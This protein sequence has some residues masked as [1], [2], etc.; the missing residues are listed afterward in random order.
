MG[1]ELLGLLTIHNCERNPSNT[2]AILS[3]V[4]GYQTVSI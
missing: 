1:G 3:E 2:H 4:F